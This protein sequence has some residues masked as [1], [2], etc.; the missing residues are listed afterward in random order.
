MER[1]LPEGVR[2]FPLRAPADE[3]D[4]IDM[5][6]PLQS[7]MPLLSIWNNKHLSSVIKW[8]IEQRTDRECLQK[9]EEPDLLTHIAH[10]LLDP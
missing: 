3:G 10:P 7:G 4:S 2:T 9:V 5:P 1:G 6:S 8:G